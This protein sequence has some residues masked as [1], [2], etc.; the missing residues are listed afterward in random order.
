M[1]RPSKV[2][3]E[4]SGKNTFTSTPVGDPATDQT[5]SMAMTIDG[6]HYFIPDIVWVKKGG[7]VT[8]EN[9]TGEHSTTAYAPSNDK[10]R[11]IPDVAK[12]WNSELVEDAGA[13]FE[14]TFD[15]PGVYDYYCIPHESLGMVG[16][17]IVGA[18]G[19]PANEPALQPP[20]KLPGTAQEIMTT[21]T[22]RARDVLS[23]AEKNDHIKFTAADDVKVVG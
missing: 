17:V 1:T 8:W 18:P 13:T 21:L 15:K 14:H 22:K 2:A 5:V 19:D 3:A 16:K 9:S 4:E 23:E 12:G 6:G 7:T 20:K 11:R 10:P